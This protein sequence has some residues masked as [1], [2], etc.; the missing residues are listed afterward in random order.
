MLVWGGDGHTLAKIFNWL[1]GGDGNSVTW[2]WGVYT[3]GVSLLLSIILSDASLSKAFMKS[4]WRKI[5]EFEWF[6]CIIILTICLTWQFPILDFRKFKNSSDLVSFCPSPH[7]KS[8]KCPAH[9]ISLWSLSNGEGSLTDHKFLWVVFQG[10]TQAGTASKFA[11]TWKLPRSKQ[12]QRVPGARD[13]YPWKY[14]SVLWE[15]V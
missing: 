9:F 15:N 5:F 2:S 6:W 4:M 14:I 3:F 11:C 8:Q 12:S 7:Y 10:P 1:R 13:I